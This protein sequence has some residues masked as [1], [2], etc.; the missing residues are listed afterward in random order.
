MA[1]MG[2][3]AGWRKMRAADLPA[4]EAISDAVHGEFT[5]P[6]AVYAER[7]VLYPDGCFVLD[8]GDAIAGYLISHPWRRDTPPKLGAS[9]GNVPAD[10]DTYYLHDIALLP[11]TR[12]SGAGKA[13]VGLVLEQAATA[14]QQDITLM[15]INGADSF[16]SARG[17]DYVPGV[18]D[19]SYGAG[20]YLMRRSLVSR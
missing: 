18:A 8:N 2:A 1:N 15:A 3:Q 12:G 13:A 10:A 7:L 4:V 9:I 20:S 19:A 6:I 5:E 14:G 11:S 16:W 17:F